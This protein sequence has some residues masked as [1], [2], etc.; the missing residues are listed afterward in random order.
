MV[1]HRL[2]TGETIDQLITQIDRDQH[3]LFY[4]YLTQRREKAQFIGQYVDDHLTAILAYIS[5]LPFPA[6][7][8]YCIE[9]EEVF[10]PELIMFAREACGL[11]DHVTCGTILYDH[12][13]QLFQSYGL[14]TGAPQRFLTM[15]HM[16]QEKLLVSHRTEHVK[17]EEYAEVVHFLQKEGMRFFTKSEIERCPFLGIKDGKNFIAVGGFHFYDAQLVEVGNI[18][19]RPDYRGKGL[20]KLLTS[21]LTRLGKQR[22]TDVYLGVL[23]ENEPAIKVYKGLGYEATAERAIVDFK[24]KPDYKCHSSSN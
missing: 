13:L 4:S 2:L 12:D 8:F 1:L 24:L 18:V 15:K 11:N 3:L 14:I 20:G 10:F 9:R 5:E 17:A 22:S 6:F 19:T 21:Q 16:D 7:A 23:S